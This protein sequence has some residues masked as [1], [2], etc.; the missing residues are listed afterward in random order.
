MKK[1]TFST[2]AA[3]RLKAN[4][5]Q[6]M[7]LVLGIF[8]SIFLIS[9]L[10]LSVWGIYQAQLEKRYDTIGYLDMV[11]LDNDNTDIVTEEAV[12]A[13]GD[14]D[15]LG[16]AYLSGVVTN[17]NLY[18][19]YYDA[20]GAELLNLSAKEGRMPENPGEIALERS[21][22]DVL[23]IQWNIGETVELSI[24][25]IDGAEETRQFTL[26]G[27]LPERSLHL[28]RIDY[29]NIGQF[30]AIITSAQEPAFETGRTAYHI[31]LGFGKTGT[32][33]KSL[34]S[35][36]KYFK[37]YQ[38]GSAIYGLSITGEQ[39]HWIGT[40]DFINSNREMFVLILMACVLA[41]SLI[42]SC[43]IGIS[44]AMEGVLSKRREEIGVLRALGATRRQIR[45]MFGREN[46]LLALILSPLSILISIGA[47]W[48]LSMLMPGNIQLAVNLWLIIPIA[49]FSVIVILVSGYLPLVRASKLMPMSVIRDTAMLRRSKGVK[50][51]KEFSATRLIASRQ[52]RFNPTRQIGAMLLVGL[53][54]LCSGALTA[55]ASQLREYATY[56]TPGFSVNNSYFGMSRLG[57]MRYDRE[58]MGK[59]SIQQ[60]KSL[61]HVEYILI[62]REM[63][64]IAQVDT[65][66]RYAMLIGNQEQFGML[67][68]EQFEEAMRWREDREYYL[69]HRE[70]DRAEY[71]QFLK[72]YN[73]EKEA[74]RMSILT[75]DLT[76][77]NVN[78][79]KAHLTEGSINVDAI[80]A[81]NQ[82]LICTPEIWVE[83]HE[84]GGMSSF[85]SNSP[86]FEEFKT[87]NSF[88]AG[89]N[90][91]F[92]A[93]QTLTLTQ[94]YTEDDT[95]TNILRND[96]QVQLCGIVDGLGDLPYNSWAN[97]FLI[98]T[99]QGLEN[100]GLRVE[101]LR[102]IEMYLD[103]EISLETEE[104]LERQINAIARRSEGFS[105]QN[106]VKN[107][108]ER[109]Q[110]NGQT[111]LLCISVV[112]VFFA[113]AVGMIVSSV[114]RQLHS[115]GRTIGM[116]RAVGADEKAILGCYSG[117]LN[118]AVLGGLGITATLSFLFLVFLILD[119][120]PY[121]Y[122][123][124][125]GQMM[126][127]VGFAVT[128]L[129]MAAACWL[130]ARQILRL[131]IREIVNKSIIDNIREL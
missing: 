20:M 8:L 9:T 46:L 118:A 129:V 44:G 30:P 70:S 83:V 93:G 22:L 58:T 10:V 86:Y 65:V 14:Y 81:G 108:R 18:V 97:C 82:V 49:L 109:E 64:I 100:M 75:V 99:E 50:S 102:G 131:R 127:L 101:G 116:L 77:E 2:M 24:T 67:N 15:R 39:V 6:Y 60:L 34:E 122:N 85:S 27:I 12:H 25:P 91:C 32:I 43:G 69:E 87:E 120:M 92:T 47:V 26:V 117:Q 94:L 68:D 21:A 55:T 106:W 4:K 124:F 123:P 115:E 66:P 61:D 104:R 105:V 31:V 103:G 73:F 98:T 79:L 48:V 90:D 37:G 19:G 62:D 36:W 130:L 7:S 76:Q 80:N 113:V 57:V 11:I 121:G 111:M 78:E 88:V 13:T 125:Q 23:D 128:V 54:L 33:A 16:H 112:T 45:K 53:M 110:A 126:M 96:A 42:L 41:G 59:Q 56:E 3:A 84:N 107:H 17:K 72:D 28:E 1:L 71:L 63:D 51:Q 52:V 74:F 119:A 5:R 95:Y 35:F 114:T 89:W 29:N 40:G 38:V